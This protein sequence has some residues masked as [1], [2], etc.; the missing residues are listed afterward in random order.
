MFKMYRLLYEVIYVKEENKHYYFFSCI[1]STDVPI[2]VILH[3][4]VND[5]SL[6]Q[7]IT[8]KV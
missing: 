1:K 3:I 5:T 2:Y 4:L 6:N 7:D 8:A